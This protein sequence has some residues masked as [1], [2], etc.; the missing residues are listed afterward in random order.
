VGSFRGVL[1][2]GPF[3]FEHELLQLE[4]ATIVGSG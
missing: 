4:R 2:L 1:R 3:G